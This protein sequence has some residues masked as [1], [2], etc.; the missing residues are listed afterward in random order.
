MI[1][2]TKKDLWLVIMIIFGGLVLMGQTTAL[3]LTK[4]FNHRATWLMLG[5][6]IFYGGVIKLLAYPI[7]Y[8]ITSSSLKIR[9][10]LLL[11]YEIPVS[12]IVGVCPTRNPL[13]AP[14]LS[15]DRLRIDYVKDGSSRFMLISPENKDAFLGELAKVA[16]DLEL[17]GREEK[18]KFSI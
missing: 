1:Y 9:S 14:A 7:Y 2:S 12:S 17:K 13:S 3:L 11:R 6:T 10:G 16:P 18:G 8:E 15:L 4:G 5:A